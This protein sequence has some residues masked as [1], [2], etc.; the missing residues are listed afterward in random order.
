MP[1]KAL[2]AEEAMLRE[3]AEVELDSDTEFKTQQGKGCWI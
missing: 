3:E 1:R 2:C